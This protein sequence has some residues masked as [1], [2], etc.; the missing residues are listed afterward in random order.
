MGSSSTV[1]SHWIQ[2]FH[3]FWVVVNREHWIV[4]RVRITIKQ[5]LVISFAYEFVLDHVI[6]SL[7]GYVIIMQLFNCATGSF[8]SE[9]KIR[10]WAN[11]TID[12]PRHTV[13][14][15]TASLISSLCPTHGSNNLSLPHSFDLISSL[16]DYIFVNSLD[17][18]VVII[19]NLMR[20]PRI[21]I[22]FMMR[23][24]ILALDDLCYH[25]PLYC[26]PTNTSLFVFA[27][28]PWVPCYPAIVLLYLGVLPSFM[29]SM[30]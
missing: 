14:P 8:P 20:S 9:H 17:K 27:V 4:N 21:S 13:G 6:P 24:T 28:I 1:I 5:L 26:L 19:I 15:W 30:S 11:L 23:N 12:L 10:R 16:V 7:F 25:R 29:S 22:E 3:G 2:I 18:C